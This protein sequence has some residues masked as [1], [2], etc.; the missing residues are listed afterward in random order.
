MAECSADANYCILAVIRII[1]QAAKV[2]NSVKIWTKC[3]EANNSQRLTSELAVAISYVYFPH[4]F[5]DNLDKS[6]L[7]AFML[8]NCHRRN[9]RTGQAAPAG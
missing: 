5:K 7:Y 8:A 1:V 6:I 9:A 4:H 3:G 2:N